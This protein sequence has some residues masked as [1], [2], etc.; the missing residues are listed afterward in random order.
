M[1]ELDFFLLISLE[2]YSPLAI[3]VFDL[4]PE[5]N[6]E[7]LF[8]FKKSYL[9]IIAANIGQGGSAISVFFYF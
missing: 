2:S 8:E 5:L 6:L 4:N 9:Y 7:I 3:V 1:W